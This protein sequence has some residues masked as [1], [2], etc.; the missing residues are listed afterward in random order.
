MEAR[1]IYLF[2]KGV[3]KRVEKYEYIY[4]TSMPEDC[5]K[6][7]LYDQSKIT[8]TIDKR[9]CLKSQIMN[10]AKNIKM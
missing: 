3:R 6:C 1:D 7:P 9:H 2:L 4:C 5:R 8:E 10:I